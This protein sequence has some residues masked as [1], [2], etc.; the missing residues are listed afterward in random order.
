MLT[1]E[2]IDRV[3]AAC[4]ELPLERVF[5]LSLAAAH[6]TLPVYQAYSEAHPKLRGHGLVHDALV[7]AW[8]VLR[9]RP[10]ASAVQ[11]TPRIE[12]AINSA[13][14]ELHLINEADEFLLPEALAAESITA[15]TLALSAYREGSRADAFNAMIGALEVDRVWAEGEADQGEH[16]GLV[17]WDRL[18]SH[19]AQQVRDI[20]LLSDIGESNEKQLFRDVAMRAEQEGMAF[21]IPMRGIVSATS[22]DR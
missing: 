14:S 9:A 8:R 19:Y 16:E 7:G 13:Q 11:L 18:M 4:Q 17:S 6:R 15:A 21:L 3:E 2:Q 12:D 20:D 10:G 22:S 1:Q 5:A